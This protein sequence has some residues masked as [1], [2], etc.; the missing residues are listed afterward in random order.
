MISSLHT[1]PTVSRD[2]PTLPIELVNSATNF[3]GPFVEQSVLLIVRHP[4]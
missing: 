1:E 3:T 2:D 4:S